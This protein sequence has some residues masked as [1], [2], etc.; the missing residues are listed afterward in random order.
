MK[1]KNNRLGV[2]LLVALFMLLHCNTLKAQINTSYASWMA[3]SMFASGVVLKDGLT[4][5]VNNKYTVTYAVTSQDNHYITLSYFSANDNITKT[6]ALKINDSLYINDI[7]PAS[8]TSAVVCGRRIS[9]TGE[10]VGFIGMITFCANQDAAPAQWMWLNTRDVPEV[11]TPLHLTAYTSPDGD[12]TMIAAFGTTEGI[13]Y[14]IAAQITPDLIADWKCAYNVYSVLEGNRL[15]DV[16]SSDTTVAFVGYNMETG[17]TVLNI[18]K[19]RYV[20]DAQT[21]SCRY[22]YF[23]NPNLLET[24]TR[25]AA[26]DIGANRIAVA[27]V[28]DHAETERLAV[29]TYN[30]ATK[31]HLRTLRSELYSGVF[32]DVAYVSGS[33]R[34]TLLLSKMDGGMAVRNIDVFATANYIDKEYSLPSMLFRNICS[35]AN[36]FWVLDNGNKEA[37]QDITSAGLAAYQCLHSTEVPITLWPTK[38]MTYEFEEECLVATSRHVY[39]MKEEHKW[40][41]IIPDMECHSEY[42]SSPEDKD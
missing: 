14:R 22:Y 19:K 15:M 24:T 40:L 31:K 34:A 21:L 20:L 7:A 11:V 16:V 37:Y 17:A 9:N 38:P 39:W 12:T 2:L 29:Q 33:T 10:R 27:L 32:I 41:S 8:D 26:T 3:T 28:L 18:S 1:T 23:T 36:N 4:T 5:N 6:K 13:Q 25:M 42:R 35:R 30:L